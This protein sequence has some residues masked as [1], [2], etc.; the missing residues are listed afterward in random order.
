MII[1][2]ICLKVIF[3]RSISCDHLSD[4]SSYI[5]HLNVFSTSNERKKEGC[6]GQIIQR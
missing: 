1:L 6:G 2:Q 4:P 5:G 3:T